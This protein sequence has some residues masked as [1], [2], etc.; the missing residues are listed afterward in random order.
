MAK[1]QIIYTSCMRGIEGVN[2]GQQ[3]FS[4]DEGFSD[5][6]SEDVKSL[7]TYQVPNLQPGVIMTEEI[8]AS[9]PAAFSFKFLNNGNTSVSLNTYLGRDYMGSAGRFGNHLCHAIV[10][11]FNDLMVYPC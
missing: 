4:Y 5:C 10:T 11:D 8:A 7:F 9:M 2:D 3:I 1:H 6:K